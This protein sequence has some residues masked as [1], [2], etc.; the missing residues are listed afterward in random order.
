MSRTMCVAVAWLLVPGCADR[1]PADDLGSTRKAMTRSTA[2]EPALRGYFLV[3]DDAALGIEPYPPPSAVRGAA[4]RAWLEAR[5]DRFDAAKGTLL[6]DEPWLSERVTYWL[7]AFPV[8]DLRLSDEEAEW[9]RRRSDVLHVSLTRELSPMTESSLAYLGLD[10]AED[11]HDVGQFRNADRTAGAGIRVAVVDT[12]IG[13]YDDA[14]DPPEDLMPSFLRRAT[15]LGRNWRDDTDIPLRVIREGRPSNFADCEAILADENTDY[16]DCVGDGFWH[17]AKRYDHGTNVG[18]IVA[19]VAPGATL[20]SL[21]VFHDIVDDEIP[22]GRGPKTRGASIRAALNAVALAGDTLVVNLS[23]G[24]SQQFHFCQP[25]QEDAVVYRE[26]WNR[27]VTVVAATGNHASRSG[28]SSPAC[29]PHVVAVGAVYDTE[30]FGEHGD[31][32]EREVLNQ[33]VEYAVCSDLPAETGEGAC[34]SDTHAAVDLLAPGVNVGWRW[35]TGTSQAA[36]HV[37]GYVA[38]LQQQ[39]L[40]GEFGEP[41]AL[42]PA[43]VRSL[44]RLRARNASAAAR[45]LRE[46]TLDEDEWLTPDLTEA[47]W[48]Q[49][50]GSEFDAE[51][52][53]TA[54]VA[55]PAG[56]ADRITGA[57]LDLAVSH[58]DTSQLTV[59]LRAPSGAEFVVDDLQGADLNSLLGAQSHRGLADAFDGLG[60]QGQFDL[61]VAVDEG[62]APGRVLFATLHLDVEQDEDFEGPRVRA[63]P[64]DSDIAGCIDEGGAGFPPFTDVTLVFEDPTAGVLSREN[65]VRTRGDGSFD[66]TFGLGCP[67]EGPRGRA[68]AYLDRVDPNDVGF[69][70]RPARYWGEYWDGGLKSTPVVE[71]TVSS[72]GECLPDCG[73]RACGTDGC[74]GLCGA[75]CFG[76]DRC[77]DGACA[78][79]GAHQLARS[80]TISGVQTW[81]VDDSPVRVTS[82]LV[83]TGHVTIRPGVVVEFANDETDMYIRD[84]GRLTAEGTAGAP[85][86][87]T[88]DGPTSRGSW[89]GIQIEGDAGQ[90]RITDADIRYGGSTDFHAIKYVL[91]AS[92]HADLVMER[93]RFVRN[94][95]NGV[96]LFTGT[97]NSDFELDLTEVPYLVTSDITVNGTLTLRPG[98][99]LK[100][101]DDEADLRIPG[102]LLAEGDPGRPVVF[103][104]LADDA[105]LGDTNGDGVSRVARSQWG[106]IHLNYADGVEQSVLRNVVISGA[107]STDFHALKVPLLLDGDTQPTF[108]NVVMRTNRING[109]SLEIGNYRSDFRLRDL[110]LPYWIS[111]DL[112]VVPGTTL[113]VDPGVVVKLEDDEVDL[114]VNG[115]LV[116]EGDRARPIVFTSGRDDNWGGDTNSNGRSSGA[117]GDWGGIHL[118][119]DADGE[120]SSLDHVSVLF[121]GSND[122]NA[123]KHTVWI[124]GRTQPEIHNTVLAG[125][126]INGLSLEWGQYAA[127]VRLNVVGIPYWVYADTGVNAGVT[128]T[129]DPGVVVKFD[130]DEADLRISGRLVAEGR[131]DAP[132]VFTSAADDAY[133]GDTNSNGQT[134]PRKGDW[135]GIQLGYD[136]SQDPDVLRHVR[137][138]YGGST[139]FNALKHT[140]LVSGY[141]QPVIGPVVMENNRVNGLSMSAGTYPADLR[142]NVTAVPYWIYAD[143]TVNPGVTMTVDPGVLL[144]FDDDEADLHINGRLVARGTPEAPIAFTAARDD[145]RGGD[146]NGDGRTPP[147]AG[148]W[149]GI[150]LNYDPDAEPSIIEHATI[151]YGGSSDFHA[152]K[153]ALWVDGRAVPE[154]R[155]VQML[156][157]RH[158]GV[159]LETGMY[160][161]DMRLNIDEIPYWIASDTGVN[162]GVTMRIDPGAVLKFADDDVDLLIDGRLLAE[163]TADAPIVFTEIRNDL[164]GGDT[165][166]DGATQ[167]RWRAWGGIRFGGDSGGSVIRHA[168]IS[169]AGS[170]AFNG[171]NCAVDAWGDVLVEDVVFSINDDAVCAR[172]A[173]VDLGGGA[174]GSA[175]GN[176]WVGHT[177]GSGSW[178]VFNQSAGDVFAYDNDWGVDADAIEEVIFDRNDDAARGEVLHDRPPVALAQDL[179][180]QEDVAVDIVLRGM[181]PDGRPV[182]YEIVDGPDDG[183]LAGA[184]PVLRYTPARDFNG[185]DA[186]SFRVFDGEARSE[187]AT[188]RITV[189]AVNDVPQAVSFDVATDED[190]PVAVRLRGTDVDGDPLQ[191]RVVE[192]PGEGRLE[193]DVP[194]LR[195]VPAEH[196]AGADLV[197]YVV[198]DGQQD[199]VPGVVRITVRPVNDPPTALAAEV[200][201]DEDVSVELTLRG[202][203]PDDEQLAFRVVGRPDQGQLRGVPPDLVYEPSPNW[204]GRSSFTFVA[205]DGEVDSE[206]AEV[207]L[208]VRPL[209]DA[210]VAIDRVVATEEDTPV[211]FELEASDADGDPLVYRVVSDPESGRLEGVAPVLTY[212]PGDDFAGADALRFAAEDPSGATGE[213]TVRIVVGGRNDAP[214]ALGAQLATDEDVP[215]EVTLRG[216]DADDDAL[217]FRV[218]DGPEDGALVGEP[219]ELVYEPPAD[220]AGRVAFRF[221][222]ADGTLESAPA[223]IEIE[224][225]PVNDR[226]VALPA[227]LEVEEDAALEITLDGQDVDGDDLRYRVTAQPERGTLEGAPPDLRYLPEPDFNG[228]DALSFV[229]EDAAGA[230]A[231]AV[232]RITVTPVND[233]PVAVGARL[234][235]DEDTPIEVALQ[236]TD[237]D[238]DPL[239]YRVVDVT[240]EGRVEGEP[241]E[242]RYTPAAD[243]SGR[244]TITFVASDGLTDSEAA[245]VEIEVAPVDDAPR[246][247]PIEDREDREADQVE[248]GLVGFEPDGEAMRWAVDALPPGVALDPATGRIAGRLGFD[249]AGLWPV[250]VT[251]SD[252][253]GA[254][255][256]TTFEWRVLDR[257]RPPVVERVEGG[258]A[259]EG[260]AMELAVV[261]SDPDG[262]PLDVRWDFG[263]GS[264][265]VRG[266][267]NVRVEHAFGDDGIF[268]VSVTVS[269]GFEAD[270]A[271]TQVTVHNVAPRF[272]GDPPRLVAAGGALDYEPV[273]VD[274]GADELVLGLLEG[275][276]GA[277]L[278]DGRLG[279]TP[280]EA[281]RLGGPYAFRLT[282]NDGDGGEAEQAWSVD[283]DVE[284]ADGDGMPD[285]CERRY[286]FDPNDPDDAEG[287]ADLDGLSNRE[288]CIG[289]GDP[290]R[291]DGPGAPAI[292]APEAGDRLPTRRPQLRVVNA[293]DPNGDPLEYLFE[294]YSDADLDALLVASEQVREG[295]E[296]TAWAVPD[297]LPE[298]G[299]FWWRARALDAHVAGA[300]S[301][302]GW[303]LVDEMNEP[304]GIP[305]PRAPDG[306]TDMASPTLEVLAVED[307]EGDAVTYHFEVFRDAELEELVSAGQADAAAWQVDVR[308]AED[309]GYWWRAAAEDALGALSVSSDALAFRVDA[310][311]TL[312][313]PPRIVAPEEEARVAETPVVLRW[314]PAEDVDGDALTYEVEV[315]AAAAPGDVVW[316]ADGIEP[317]GAPPVRATLEGLVED[318]RYEARVRARDRG[319]VGPA[320]S[321]RFTVNAE[322]TPPGRP[323]LTAPADGAVLPVGAVAL[324]FE[325]ATDPDGDAVFHTLEVFAD[326]AGAE[327]LWSREA[328]AIDE[329]GR[330]EVRWD[331]AEPARRY[332]WR[333]G[334]TDAR[335]LAGLAAGPRAFAVAQL[336]NRPPSAPRPLA[337]TGDVEVEPGVLTLEV[338]NAIDSDGEALRYTFQLYT[339]EALQQLASE[340]E[341]VGEGADGTTAVEVNYDAER[342]VRLFWRAFATDERGARGV[343]SEVAR[344]RIAAAE[345][346]AGLLAEDAGPDAGVRAADVGLDAGATVVD[347]EATDSGIV[348]EVVANPSDGEPSPD[349]ALNSDA[350]SDGGCG[351][352]A[353]GGA[354][355]MWGILVFGRRRRR[356]VPISS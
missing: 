55:L 323:E 265:E 62:G 239:S 286:G 29:N 272:V 28:V 347:S 354:G 285:P 142:L 324:A 247:D 248:F 12:G 131:P 113:T 302:V 339:D 185:V 281:Q 232:V 269:D 101:E 279:W 95:Y 301:A 199:S 102:R 329:Q 117:R 151:A 180:T 311:N 205:S 156:S 349:G 321:V 300:W 242:L 2:A 315:A 351:C 106:G 24:G 71:Y 154:I 182:E 296:T 348:G 252:P 346:D 45:I 34:F 138:H 133:G 223:T 15:I 274:P 46:L 76:T 84:G 244:A 204:S 183:A 136:P 284:D 33:N 75:G 137:I 80:G 318:V 14:G 294:A 271:E 164:A 25:D 251:A 334:A 60:V 10:A 143:V 220:W 139:D 227:N 287:D 250:R 331:G 299:R 57:W 26:L 236:A 78:D 292:A 27:G 155:S 120:P 225:R 86:V 191:L 276:E 171:G 175:G 213:A 87:F 162:A 115:R 193:G 21:N 306:R 51:T 83:I 64:G 333:V 116:A 145:D 207:V 52:S 127:D 35:Q 23:L 297:A 54:A 201:T 56:P 344:F 152:I 197:R 325:A 85:V 240:A 189:V 268:D 194:D 111:S 149:G 228:A 214:V 161:A 261:A 44:L 330:G 211:D 187:P 72:G 74:G 341:D 332:W 275:P 47:F 177:P 327:R 105:W 179:A 146:T 109:V 262:D 184:P 226:P 196:F 263:D 94:R 141:N 222:A 293:V 9:L 41:G 273:L 260:A 19:A 350:P 264:P 11:P 243:W 13:P 61:E 192:G 169:Y 134:P 231:P 150:H 92:G 67:E 255:A 340:S 73:G 48:Q 174:R 288:E 203:D 42:T 79:P 216:M 307:P 90:V 304:P 277:R 230:S 118:N 356:K 206:P 37:A 320:A 70:D 221:V 128:M 246:F 53:F 140:L 124:D 335:G 176:R 289:G 208:V 316:G 22:G 256:E 190:L 186:F 122:F 77:V 237:V 305:A 172:V 126:R 254:S 198:N 121:G 88:S 148:H 322:N 89:G 158:N 200:V 18:S 295:N 290:R 313:T 168:G 110:G 3:F 123:I 258:E 218:I 235:T 241:P 210:P 280:S 30:A 217:T 309:V 170:G 338:A 303:A 178:A 31:A 319:G 1:A 317:D 278:E 345:L 91:N 188:V 245:V 267:D 229:V 342:G 328:V 336:D 135:G 298:N 66:W 159:T 253:G 353:T 112:T 59:T 163:G 82:D 259:D 49:P 165:N 93:V 99:V 7:R 40:A 119:Y 209:N 314:L 153:Y 166:R 212:I 326:E 20:W 125:N 132:I 43:Q 249:A 69:E 355:W 337:P 224:V 270:D 343:S 6:G 291:F 100:F 97:Y 160:G 103:T 266:E 195:Y 202:T 129:I 65:A 238:E 32:P 98:V 215:L 310:E 308:L 104:S 68:T 114:H 234:E 63:V 36:P 96:R 39:A 283:V 144:K 352:D 312:P 58:P 4:N 8:L 181:D 157:N 108:E 130:D 5:W 257:N 219:P 17:L 16:D 282:V 233:P 147:G 38:W 167:P 50:Q 107:G 81:T 173:S